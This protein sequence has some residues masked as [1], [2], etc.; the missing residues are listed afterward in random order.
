MLG[1]TGLLVGAVFLGSVFVQTV[2][3]Y[4]ALQAGLA[5]LPMA[6]VLIV[7]TRL[8]SHLL[9]HVPPRLVAAGGLLLTAGACGEVVRR[10]RTSAEIDPRKFAA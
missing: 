7:G 3:G 2:L 1:V 6:A 9:G 8:G 10:Y 5:F 4:T